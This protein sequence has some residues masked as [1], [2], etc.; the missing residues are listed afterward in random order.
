MSGE[1]ERDDA[2]VPGPGRDHEAL[3]RP[4]RVEPGAKRER[5]AEVGPADAEVVAEAAAEVA[6]AAG[7]AAFSAHAA[8][9]GQADVLRARARD[10]GA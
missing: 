7:Q 4:V 8:T 2:G 1:L 6:V 10:I 9:V 3:H 5:V